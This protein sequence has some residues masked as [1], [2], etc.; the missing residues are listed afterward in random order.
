MV[1]GG[2]AA[3]LVAAFVLLRAP[4]GPRSLRV[5]APDRMAQL[6][7]QMWQAYYRKEKV[8]LFALLV[9]MLHE[10]NRYSWARALQAGTH[11]ARAAATFGD[12]RSGYEQVEPDLAIAYRIARDWT[13]A[14]FDPAQVARAELAWWVARR[15]PGEQAPGNVGR[16][17]ASEYALLYEA[18][19]ERVAE[20][21]LLRAEAGALRDEEGAQA[22]WD[23]LGQLLR[24]SYRSLHA[25]L[26]R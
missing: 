11:L 16:L 23:R 25:A 9:T 18:P 5:F 8:R 12:A 17:I 4:G 19:V 26:Q 24:A 20:A 3:L 6:E 2:L 1:A 21:G 15:T 7:L 13:G 10:Q 22:D 14:G